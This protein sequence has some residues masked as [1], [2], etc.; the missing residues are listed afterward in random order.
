M[1]PELALAIDVDV[2]G[3]GDRANDVV[4][5]GAVIGEGGDPGIGDFP[6]SG[7]IDGGIAKPRSAIGDFE[8][9]AFGK[10]EA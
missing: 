5:F 4:V 2:I 9:V 10:G 7:L 3:A 1:D 6:V 8:F